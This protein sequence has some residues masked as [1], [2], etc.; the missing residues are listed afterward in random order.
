M[1]GYVVLVISSCHDKK[2]LT[3]CDVLVN[4]KLSLQR[5]WQVMMY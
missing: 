2:T 3:C 4:V 1:T 5:H